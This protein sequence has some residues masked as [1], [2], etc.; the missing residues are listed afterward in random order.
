MVV[1]EDS[2]VKAG[3]RRHGGG[4]REILSKKDLLLLAGCRSA[5]AG[6]RS[7]IVGCQTLLS[8]ARCCCRCRMLLPDA[9]LL[10][11]VVSS[12]PN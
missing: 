11:P 7:V 3:E 9:D 1:D 2:W 10:L 12:S 5:V 4:G 6:C 8:D